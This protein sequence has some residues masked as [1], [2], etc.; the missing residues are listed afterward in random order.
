RDIHVTGVQTCA[1]PICLDAR[2]EWWYDH[3]SGMVYVIPPQGR[4]I[5]QIEFRGKHATYVVE[6]EDCADLVMNGIDFFGATVKMD[7]C[8]NITVRD[9]HFKF[10]AYSRRMLG[11]LGPVPTT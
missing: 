3:E 8:Q 10:P 11:E 1:L 5:D 2:N 9:A 4:Q 7:R 6:M